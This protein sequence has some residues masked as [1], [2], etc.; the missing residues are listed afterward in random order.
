MMENI[1][2]LPDPQNLSKYSSQISFEDPVLNKLESYHTVDFNENEK[3][4]P[5]IYKRSLPKPKTE[6]IVPNPKKN[7][8]ECK[9]ISLE[10]IIESRKKREFSTKISPFANLKKFSSKTII[11]HTPKAFQNEGLSPNFHAKPEDFLKK[12]LSSHF[13]FRE[14]DP[15]IL[16]KLVS[17]L[18]FIK[19]RKGEVLIEEKTLVTSFYI[20]AKGQILSNFNGVCQEC[21]PGHLLCVSAIFQPL[22]SGYHIEALEDS[23]VWG[24]EF[25]KF[26]QILKINAYSALQENGSFLDNVP[27]FDY[28]TKENK[29]EIAFYMKTVKFYPGDIIIEKNTIDEYL[30]IIRSGVLKMSLSKE[31]DSNANEEILLKENE[32]FGVDHLEENFSQFIK[33]EVDQNCDEAILLKVSKKTLSLMLGTKYVRMMYTEELRY[34]FTKTDVLVYLD[35]IAKEKIIRKL[36]ISELNEGDVVWNK[37]TIGDFISKKNDEIHEK[38]NKNQ[39]KKL[40][41]LLKGEIKDENQRTILKKNGVLHEEI[42]IKYE[43]FKYDYEKLSMSSSGVIAEISFDK[44]RQILN[45]EN[46]QDYFLIV[47]KRC[48]KDSSD[49]GSPISPFIHIKSINLALKTC[50]NEIRLN[51][52]YEYVKI[53]KEIGDGQFGLVLL[54]AIEGRFFALKVISRFW[55]MQNCI[56]DYL[57]NE[58]KICRMID[59]PF[60]IHLDFTFRDEYNI[61]FLFEYIDGLDLFKFMNISGIVPTNIAK[62][63]SANLILALEYL[64]NMKIIHRD[65]KPENIMISKTG[66]LKVIDLGAAKHLGETFSCGSLNKHS[67]SSSFS[68]KKIPEN[69]NELI[70]LHRTYTLIGTPEYIAPETIKGTGYYFPV[71]IWALGVIIYEML[72]GF[73]PFGQN[74]EDPMDIYKSIL[75]D[76]VK[77]PKTFK[78]SKAKKLIRQLLSKC[79]EERSEGSLNSLKAKTWFNETPWENIRNLEPKLPPYIPENQ[80]NQQEIE[81]LLAKN[82]TLKYVLEKS[83]LEDL[84]KQAEEMG[85]Q[86]TQGWDEIF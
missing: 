20:I 80:E 42:L 71:D 19:L 11:I 16:E 34:L 44:L 78:D 57:V 62:F 26:Q 13:L 22:E 3:A 46:L 45:T 73:C 40:V 24:V 79:P 51:H 67:N 38:N 1:K 74:K 59:N 54:A 56:E 36:K 82:I 76:D 14:W 52:N 86:G 37:E 68:F 9:E 6:I 39:E 55:V 47:K 18:Q 31:E 66:Y 21:S 50:I 8:S 32:V 58:K 29:V 81:R 65:L 85:M 64:H 83:G 4:S 27:Y 23:E 63:Y 60:I 17:E 2:N 84:K 48:K 33:V 43:E 35:P 77:F 70:T 10:E 28:L 53:I 30:Y 72:C 7:N 12:N 75:E 69:E 49:L 5:L 15:Y 61:Y 25:V 41:F